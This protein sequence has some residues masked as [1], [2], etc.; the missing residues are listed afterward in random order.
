MTNKETIAKV[1]TSIINHP[2]Q[3]SQSDWISTV[4]PNDDGSY[5]ALDL[6]DF[7]SDSCDTS[8]CIAGWAV[9]HAGYRVTKRDVSFVREDGEG[10]YWTERIFVKDGKEHKNLCF[11]VLGQEILG[12]TGE[13]AGRLFYDFSDEESIAALY[14]IYTTDKIHEDLLAR[15]SINTS[16]LDEDG[17]YEE[18]FREA[19]AAVEAK[20]TELVAEARAEFGE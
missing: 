15:G 14:S 6:E 10:D 5:E 9:L 18:A 3:H 4:Q 11:D 13:T 8:A 1:L 7:E 2:E 17:T 20:T 19:C 12:L 16:L